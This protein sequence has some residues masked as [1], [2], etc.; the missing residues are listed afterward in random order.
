MAIILAVAA[1]TG[2][3]V[4]WH[5]YRRAND[6]E[7]RAERAVEF[8]EESLEELN[9]ERATSR[10]WRHLHCSAEDQ[11]RLMEVAS[12]EAQSIDEEWAE[13]DGDLS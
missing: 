10:L 6:E 13:L 11:I 7:G 1:V 2:W 8:A 4:A 9:Q 12:M 5:Q 3:G